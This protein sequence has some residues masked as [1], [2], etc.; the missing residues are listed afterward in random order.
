VWTRIWI[1]RLDPSGIAFAPGSAPTELMRSDL[2][3]EGNVI[4]NRSLVRHGGQLYLFYSGNEWRSAAYA[5]GYAECAS[6]TG[7]CAKRS[8][9]P[10]LAS[11]DGRL[12][13]GGS[14]A[15]VDAQGQLQLAYHY[16]NAPYTGYPVYP[17]CEQTRS[18]TTQGQRRLRVEPA[19]V[20]AAVNDGALWAQRFVDNHRPDAV[21]FLGWGHAAE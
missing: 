6:P 3:W 16:W 7:P 2:V 5:I 21:R 10:L 4:A 19:G 11:R 18:C 17:E 15:F 9:S 12:G 20:V 8:V 14:S 13:P 1:R